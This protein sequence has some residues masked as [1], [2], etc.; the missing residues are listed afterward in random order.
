MSSMT[1]LK[2][3]V[4]MSRMAGYLLFFLFLLSCHVLSVSAQDSGEIG[5]IPFD[6]VA[7][8]EQNELGEP[9]GSPSYL[10]FDSSMDEIYVQ[11]G[12]KIVVFGADYYPYVS[13]GKGRGAVNA[14]GMAIDRHGMLYLC[15]QSSEDKPP[16]ITVFNGAFFQVREIFFKGFDGAE[17]F[18]PKR[19][20]VSQDGLIYVSSIRVPGVVVLNQ[21]GE[22]LRW[23]KPMGKYSARVLQEARKAKADKEKQNNGD[24]EGEG[25][26]VE[27]GEIEPAADDPILGLPAGLIPKKKI[28]EEEK[29]VDGQLPVL[30]VD[31]DIDQEGHIYL[32]SE[33]ESKIYVYSANEEFLYSFGTKGG[34]SGK[35]SRPRGLAVDEKKKCV[36]VID[37]MRQTLVIYDLVGKY[38]QEFGGAGWGPGSF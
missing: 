7:I 16:R 31:I 9:I 23:M 35:L 18:E 5:A 3:N 13:L 2:D 17:D 4:Q 26:E 30:I 6:V 25:A 1:A 20:A 34:S 28:V 12:G 10:M 11:S 38:L 15:Q 32:L 24:R 37:Y 21:Q 36:Y 14:Q 29:T 22:F 27:G 8:L 19:V 33:S